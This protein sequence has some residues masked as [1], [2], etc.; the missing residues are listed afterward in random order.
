MINSI[1]GFDS[2]HMNGQSGPAFRAVLRGNELH[3]RLVPRTI[4]ATFITEVKGYA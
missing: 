2:P 3:A 4:D 1:A